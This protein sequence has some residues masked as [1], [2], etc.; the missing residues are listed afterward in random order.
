LAPG[1]LTSPVLQEFY[2]KVR[3]KLK[4]YV[5]AIKKGQKRTARDN[6]LELI[7]MLSATHEFI[8]SQTR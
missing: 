3:E 5:E 2:E 1:L 6:I 8:K 7:A 4:G